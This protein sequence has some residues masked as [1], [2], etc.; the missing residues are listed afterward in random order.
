MSS[1]RSLIYL[2]LIVS[3]FLLI[4]IPSSYGE[5][6]YA[7]YIPG[8]L[9]GKCE[10][11]HSGSALDAYG[12]DFASISNHASNPQGAINAI[13]DLDS[14]GDG[15]TNSEE[16]SKGTFPGDPSSRPESSEVVEFPLLQL[17]A[18]GI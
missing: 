11:C 16:L 12:Q 10:A 1:I 9:N 18:I 3:V 15:F 5:E 7:P 13:A 17:A 6:E 2:G 14:D 8:P 4:N